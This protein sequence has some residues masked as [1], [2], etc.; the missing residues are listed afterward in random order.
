[1]LKNTC[2]KF[3]SFDKVTKRKAT[4]NSI[5]KDL[6]LNKRGYTWS[7]IADRSI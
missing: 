1:M 6:K 4:Y 3:L 2:G 7:N 5:V